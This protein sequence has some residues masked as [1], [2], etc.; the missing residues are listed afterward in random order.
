LSVAIIPN[1]I[2]TPIAVAEM[3]SSEVNRACCLCLRI[4][5]SGKQTPE[6]NREMII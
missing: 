1:N 6:T 3:I 5:I 4:Y 2:P